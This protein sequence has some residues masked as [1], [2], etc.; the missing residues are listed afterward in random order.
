MSQNLSR[1]DSQPQ[2][3]AIPL[4]PAETAE[5][6]SVLKTVRFSRSSARSLEKEAAD[7]GTTV[8]ALINSIIHQ[9]YEWDKKSRES[10]FTSINKTVLK[11]LIEELDEKTLLRVGRDVV[12]GWIEEMAEYWFQDS[13]PERILDA[14]SLR[15]KF[16]PLMRMEVTKTGDDYR[17]V[18]RHDLGSKWSFYLEGAAK[19]IVDTFFHVEPRISRGESVVTATFTANRAP[20]TRT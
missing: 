1:D 8:N 7:E 5:P 10:G 6:K 16:D 15:F 14:L 17:A 3:E 4:S 11:A 13:G 12:P 9:H 20:T 19:G 18:L 2:P